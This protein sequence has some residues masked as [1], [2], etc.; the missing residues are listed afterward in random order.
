MTDDLVYMDNQSTTRVDPR[1]VAAMSPFWSAIYGNPG[2]TSHPFGWQ[3]KEA[4]DTARKQIAVA[5]G[6]EPREIVFTSGATESNNLAIR[7]V[8]ERRKRRGN[9]II[10]VTTEHKAV[11]DPLARLAQREF[12]VTLLHPAPHF[13][14]P[15]GLSKATRA[16]SHDRPGWLDPRH[17]AD[18]I[19]DDT[20]LV[21]VMLANNEIGTIQP[22]A[23]IGQICKER[24]VLLHTDAT[25]AVGRVPV[26]VG[27]LH[28]DLMSFSAHKLYGPKGV[29]ALY[30]RRR[31]PNVRLAAQIDGGGQERGMRSG[32]LNVPA[33]MGFAKAIELSTDDIEN[34]AN[35]C[36]GLRRSLHEGLVQRIPNIHLN[37]PPLDD[38]DHR[39]AGN[40]N[41]RFDGVDGEALMLSMGNLAVSSG[42]ACTSATPEPSHVLR[43]LGLSVDQTRSSLRFGLGRFNTMKDVEFAI[44][45][46]AEA[47][48]RLRKMS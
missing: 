32:T 24:N 39:L 31:R 18:A 4:V 19:R 20:L 33:I 26:N 41:M 23:E 17:V 5:I 25:Q 22:L 44:E 2:S 36:F 8:A 3:A 10:S 12:E 47:V 42:S 30:V 27:E 43:A 48:E 14:Q 37:G 6:A 11:L 28:V 46:V 34:E 45:T 35:R 7:G 9:H 40:L 13:R 1:V 21:S 15:D 38:Q 29:G 16:L